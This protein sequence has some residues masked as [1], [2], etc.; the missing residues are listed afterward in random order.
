MSVARAFVDEVLRGWGIGAPVRED[1]V[2]VV[3]ELVANAR[4]HAAGPR[5][6]GV[7]LDADRVRVEVTDTAAAAVPARRPARADRPGGHGL[8]VV[9]RLSSRWGTDVRPCGKS[10]WAE[11]PLRWSHPGPG[12]PRRGPDQPP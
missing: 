9:E 4:Q 7:D 11:C 2:L 5:E 8:V 3:S 1:V 6:I 12:R 10:V